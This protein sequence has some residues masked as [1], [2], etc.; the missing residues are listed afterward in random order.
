MNHE[1]IKLT[2]T[3]LDAIVKLAEGDP[4][5]GVVCGQLL[6]Q[7]AEI[8]PDAAMEGLTNL[9]ALDTHAIYGCDIWMLYKDVCKENLAHVVGLLRAAQLGILTEG[10]LKHAIQNRGDGIDVARTFQD[11]CDRLPNFAKANAL[12]ATELAL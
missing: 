9:L 2:D 7:G 11:V 6:K 12:E 8:D 3:A 4:G 5:A 10:A 1:R